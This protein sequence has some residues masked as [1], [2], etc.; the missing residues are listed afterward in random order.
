M[1]ASRDPRYELDELTARLEAL[2]QELSERVKESGRLEASNFQLTQRLERAKEEL[3]RSSPGQAAALQ[4]VLDDEVKKQADLRDKNDRLAAKLAE[5]TEGTKTLA[6]ELEAAQAEVKQKSEEAGRLEAEL[7]QTRAALTAQQTLSKEQ[8]TRIQEVA[9]EA[10]AARALT[11]EKSEAA[12]T[13][14]ARLD[15]AQAALTAQQNLNETQARGIRDLEES[16][17][18]ATAGAEAA[19]AVANEKSEAAGTLQARLDEAQVALTD[20]QNVNETQARGIRDLEDSLGEATARAEAAHDVLTNRS[21]AAGRLESENQRLQDELQRLKLPGGRKRAAGG[22]GDGGGD[23]GGGGGRGGGGGGGGGPGGIGQRRGYVTGRVF[24]KFEEQSLRVDASG[25]PPPPGLGGAP[26][27]SLDAIDFE[28]KQKVAIP[29]SHEGEWWVTTPDTIPG[30][31]LD[32]RAK[33]WIGKVE[34]DAIARIYIPYGIFVDK[35]QHIPVVPVDGAAVPSY[36]TVQDVNTLYLAPMRSGSGN[37]TEDVTTGPSPYF[38]KSVVEVDGYVTMSDAFL[39][40]KA[41]AMRI[42]KGV[43]QRARGISNEDRDAIYMV[44]DDIAADPRW[45][46]TRGLGASREDNARVAATVS[47][48]AAARDILGTRRDLGKSWRSSTIMADLNRVANTSALDFAR[49]LL[50]TRQPERVAGGR[51]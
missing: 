19:Q 44:V 25:T 17:G 2:D 1:S 51:I 29:F 50:A 12:G 10:E 22:R 16:L 31:A 27:G 39:Q 28:D 26:V 21:Q 5:L 38:G 49:S 47:L 30:G 32:I 48:F 45:T 14:Q 35:F 41:E 20:Q 34:G 42:V 13:L 23:G 36:S 46:M 8:A 18:E 24:Q 43:S 7:E 9:A 11:N 37:K 40:Q 15:E 3:A 6:A 4:E 33:P